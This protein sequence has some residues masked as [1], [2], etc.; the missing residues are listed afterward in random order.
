MLTSYVL[1]KFFLLNFEHELYLNTLF[2]LTML[3][4]AGNV[5]IVR[6]NKKVGGYVLC[7]EE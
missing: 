4:K 3:Q 7:K 6:R 5:V 1:N 2:Q